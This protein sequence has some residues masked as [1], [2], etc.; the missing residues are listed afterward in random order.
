MIILLAVVFGVW[1]LVFG[2]WCLV[3]GVWCLVF[4]VWCLVFGV[5]CLVVGGYSFDAS[6][7]LNLT[8][9]SLIVF[10]GT[11]K[12]TPEFCLTTHSLVT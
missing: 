11:A 10:T 6:H 5:W 9:Q 7:S 12:F 2:V 8:M 3:F 4:G 1:C